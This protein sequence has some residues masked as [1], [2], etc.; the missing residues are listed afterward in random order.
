MSQ[1]WSLT[2]KPDV[3]VQQVRSPNLGVTGSHRTG[4]NTDFIPCSPPG[5][6]PAFPVGIAAQPLCL[7][8]PLSP[9][10]PNPGLQPIRLLG[11]C[12]GHIMN[13]RRVVRGPDSLGSCPSSCPGC[14]AFR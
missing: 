1:R 9:Q 2:K 3:G 11:P 6:L 13:S 10:P 5:L 12:P 8:R 14:S 7:L 4:V